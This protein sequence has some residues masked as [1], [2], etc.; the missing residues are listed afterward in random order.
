MYASEMWQQL[1]ERHGWS[2]DDVVKLKASGI[3][4]LINQAWNEGYEKGKETGVSH[5][6]GIFKGMFGG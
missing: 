3:K 5:G 1:Q 4:K 6:E 2:D